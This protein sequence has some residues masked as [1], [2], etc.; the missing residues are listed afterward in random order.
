MGKPAREEEIAPEGG[1]IQMTKLLRI[2]LRSACAHT[3]VLL[4]PLCLLVRFWSFGSSCLS[5]TFFFHP[6]PGPQRPGGL[7]R[8]ALGDAAE[9]G[10]VCQPRPQDDVLAD[11]GGA[12]GLE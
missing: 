4:G 1:G 12:P 9:A 5:P 3:G 11:P 10:G 8:A 6:P 7:L 2:L